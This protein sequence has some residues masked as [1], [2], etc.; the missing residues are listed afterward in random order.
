MILFLIKINL[1][2]YLY[3]NIYYMDPKIF[4]N[5]GLLSSLNQNDMQLFN[6]IFNSINNGENIN[7]I[8]ISAKEQN[9]LISKL[10]SNI[11]FNETPKKELK[12]MNEQEKKIYKEELRQKIKNKQNELKI[13][14]T[15]NLAKQQMATNTNYSEAIGKLSEM[16]KNIDPTNLQSLNSNISNENIQIEKVSNIAEKTSELKQENIVNFKQEI[17]INNIINQ[18]N[19]ENLINELDEQDKL[20]NYLN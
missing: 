14:R 12:D 18:K 7:N 9:N 19:N 3:I 6:Q 17:F 11:A 5:L 8:K 15:C 20:D 1:N 16:M 10:T 4:K 2:F 13:G